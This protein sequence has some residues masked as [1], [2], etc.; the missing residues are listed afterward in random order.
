M[1]LLLQC[2]GL[3]SLPAHQ[4][5]FTPRRNQATLEPLMR[6][7]PSET[8]ANQSV[9]LRSSAVLFRGADVPQNLQEIAR[10]TALLP[11]AHGALAG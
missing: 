3:E 6:A 8:S 1:S 11:A 7:A 2:N 5:W 9:N 10:G 4:L